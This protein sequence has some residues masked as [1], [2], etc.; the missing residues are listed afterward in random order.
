MDKKRRKTEPIWMQ[1]TLP[2]YF[3]PKKQKLSYIGLIPTSIYSYI[4]SFLDQL[5]NVRLSTVNSYSH[6]TSILK[7]SFPLVVQFDLSFLLS[8]SGSAFLSSSSSYSSSS[9]TYSS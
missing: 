3:N 7:T 4:F 1:L 2:S 6:R 5:S 8:Y 9:T